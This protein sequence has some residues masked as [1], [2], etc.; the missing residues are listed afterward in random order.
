MKQL[1][2]LV[3]VVLAIVATLPAGDRPANCW[4]THYCVGDGVRC[5]RFVRET[6]FSETLLFAVSPI[7]YWECN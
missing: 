6:V 2:L 7:V 4:S 1:Y 5:V 3:L